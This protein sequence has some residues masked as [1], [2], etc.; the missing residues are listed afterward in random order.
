MFSGVGETLI[1]PKIT[2]L[3]EVAYFKVYNPRFSILSSTPPH[4][5]QPPLH[6]SS[7]IA[8]AKFVFEL[9]YFRLSGLK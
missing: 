5:P 2:A 3:I 7:E 4:Q 1:T 9:I 6:A 8:K